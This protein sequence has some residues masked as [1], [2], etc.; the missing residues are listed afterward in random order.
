MTDSPLLDPSPSRSGLPEPG[1]P[2]QSNGSRPRA[3][4]GTLPTHPLSSSELHRGP[5]L[6]LP[7]PSWRLTEDCSIFS[8]AGSSPSSS[9]RRSSKRP[10]ISSSD[11]SSQSSGPCHLLRLACLPACRESDPC[12]CRLLMPSSIQYSRL[13]PRRYLGIFLTVDIISVSP[14]RLDRAWTCTLADL[15]VIPS[16]PS[17]L[18]VQAAGGS[19]ASGSD[20]SPSEIHTAVAIM[21]GGIFWQLVSPSSVPPS[22]GIAFHS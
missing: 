6:S 1:L 11:C 20:P 10:T 9:A 21:Q 2:V 14:S 4:T 13:T 12:R 3:A 22:A 18:F 17:Q 19:A 15:H 7:L 16:A 5:V 8:L